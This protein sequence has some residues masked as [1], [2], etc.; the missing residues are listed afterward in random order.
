MSIF[1]LKKSIFFNKSNFLLKKLFLFTKNRNL[2]Y[3]FEKKRSIFLIQ[4]S[5]SKTFDL[6]KKNRL[7]FTFST[8]SKKT[9]LKTSISFSISF[10]HVEFR[11]FFLICRKNLEFSG[12]IFLSKIRDHVCPFLCCIKLE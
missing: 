3:F 11:T 7:F 1:L 8:L 2:N 4:I 12:K 10:Q 6:F 9:T 5:L